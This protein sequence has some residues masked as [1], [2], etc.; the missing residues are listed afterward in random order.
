M[1][2]VETR[3]GR[4][5]AERSEKT[6]ELRLGASGKKGDAFA[7]TRLDTRGLLRAAGLAAGVLLLRGVKKSARARAG[8]R[9]RA[10]KNARRSEKNARRTWSKA[11]ETVMKASGG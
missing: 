5:Y 9:K 8:E 1:A 4:F 7:S 6:G 10:Q 2:T 3:F 11:I